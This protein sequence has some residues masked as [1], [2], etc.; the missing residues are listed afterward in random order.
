MAL[1]RVD[2]IVPGAGSTLITV[3]YLATLEGVIHKVAVFPPTAGVS[4]EPQEQ[5]SACLV[6]A[7]NLSERSR[8]GL[9]RSLRL[10]SATV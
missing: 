9:I 6:E 3:L 7:I 5:S 10:H 1:D 2:V 8:P 4:D